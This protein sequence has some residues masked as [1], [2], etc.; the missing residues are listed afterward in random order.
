MCEP[1]ESTARTAADLASRKDQLLRRHRPRDS[2][3]TISNRAEGNFDF[4]GGPHACLLRSSISAISRR[5]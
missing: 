1:G 5:A 4:A 3:R 2:S